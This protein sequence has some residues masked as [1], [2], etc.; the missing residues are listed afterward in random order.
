[1]NSNSIEQTIIDAVE[2]SRVSRIPVLF[3]SNPGL[4]KTTIL[5]RYA[6]HREMHLETLIGSR[7][8]PEEISGYQVNNGGDHLTHL[9]PE[10]F[11]RI[12]EKAETGIKTLLFIDELS[13]CSEFVQG[14]LLSLIFDRTIGSG[15]YLPQD[16][17]I[18][19]AA[20]YAGNL[21]QS[22]NIMAPT[23][24]RFVI[25][26]LNH[27]YTALD[28][29]SEFLS[30]PPEPVY[31]K[32][33]IS[34]SENY[35]SSF[36]DKFRNIWREI[37]FKYS[38]PE[39]K[40]GLIDIGNQKIDG[41][42]SESEQ[43]IYNFISGRSLSYLARCLMAY[44]GLGLT[45][46]NVLQKM[47]DGLVGAGS[48]MFSKE[49]GER[50]RETLYSLFSNLSGQ[51]GSVQGDFQPLVHDISKDVASFLMN[52]ENSSFTQNDRENQ[53]MEIMQEINSTF[54]VKNV[55]A[56]CT[57]T[58]GCAK[59]VADMD[60]LSEL[61]MYIGKRGLSKDAYS[62]IS[63][64]YLDWYGFY[65]QVMCIQCSYQIKFG[66]GDP[67][68]M[69]MCFIRFKSKNG[70]QI[71]KAALLRNFS[72]NGINF[73]LYIVPENEM[74]YGVQRQDAFVNSDRV[75]VLDYVRNQPRFLPVREFFALENSRTRLLTAIQ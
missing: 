42:Y 59:F 27:N 50:Y 32:K 70:I 45:N 36:M 22:M 35:K 39:S 19:A 41:L 18:V 37:F 24:N 54:S 56:Q 44:T 69:R 52:N 29:I 12:Q 31:P 58:A 65:C 64:V 55:T 66:M 28:M 49:Q 20:N 75:E 21:P 2:I 38:D 6:R 74:Y 1:M 14:S 61:Q 48:C 46:T 51:T 30:T 34:F 17:L 67:N 8:T 68:F 3:M 25:I 33:C 72:T 60:A 63:R 73:G 71:A 57:D 16:C 43:C 15:K 11:S 4:G 10:W 5:T 40:L 7:F 23:L 9:S 13:T 62:M 53:L 26:N 47:I